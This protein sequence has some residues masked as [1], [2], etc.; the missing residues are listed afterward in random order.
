MKKITLLIFMITLAA[1]AQQPFDCN[2]GNFYQVISGVM[3]AYDPITGSYSEALHSYEAYNAGGY[4]VVD[5]YL[6]AIKN[7]DKH[8]LRVAK[9]VVIDLGKVAANGSTQF[10][11]GYAADVDDLGNLWVFQNTDKQ[12]FHKIT[13]LS[14]YDGTSAPVFEIV[15]TDQAAPSNCA[16]IAFIDGA[17]YGGSKGKLFT[18]DLSSGTPVFSSKA[19][20]NLPNS[21]FGA[22]YADATNRLYLSDNKGG[23]YLINDY[24]GATPTATLL[25][26]T[27]TTNSNDGFKCASGISPLDRDQD[28]ILDS[29]D[30]DCDGDG[31]N[32]IVESKGI[33]PY[34]DHDGDAMYNYLDND[35]SG[36][37]DNVVQD[38]FDRDGDGNPDFLDVDSDN[39]GIYDIV[40][41]GEG[42]KDSNNDGIYNTL[43][44]GYMDSDHDGIAD[45]FDI[46]Q[47]GSD[48]IPIDTDHDTIY[49]CYDIDSDNDGIVDIIEGQDSESYTGLSG[50]DEDADGMDDAFDPDFGNTTN[51]T[52]NTDN[53]NDGYD[54]LDTDSDNN[55][56]LDQTEAYDYDGDGV[57][58]T[59][60][61]GIDNDEDG[62]DDNYDLKKSSFDPENGNQNPSSFPVP[63]I[64]DRYNYLGDFSADGTPLYLDERDT[65]SQETLD[66]I[67]NALPE[68]YP[69]P[70]YNPHYISSGYDTD[71][72]L[73]EQADIWVT[74]VGEGA[75]YKNTLGFYTYDKDAPSA[76]APTPEDITI[77]F[78]NVSAAGSG[79]SLQVGDKVKIGTFPA[80]TGIGWVLLANAWSD[81]CVGTGHWQVHSNPDY[82]PESNASLR[83][84]NVLL[85]DPDNE[86][87]ILGFEDIRR[88]YASCDQDFNDALFYITANPYDAMV[89]TNY[90]HIETATPVTSGN[91][92]GLES[93]GDLANLIAKR[94]FI[95][96]KTNAVYDTKK[97]QK[98]F[99]PGIKSYRSS[100]NEDLSIHFPKTGLLGTETTYVSSPEDLLGITNAQSVFSVDYYNGEERVAAAL[101]TSTKG[102]IYDHSKTI[103]DR[104]NGSTL[105]DVR[106]VNIK[107]HTLVSTR[108]QRATGEIEYTLTFSVR[109]EDS[110]NE[111]YSLWNI[112][113]YPAG[114][115]VNF[116][117]WG[118]SV[119]Q[120]SKIAHHI[121]DSFLADKPMRSHKVAQSIPTVFAQKGTYANGKLTLHIIN[122]EGATFMNF[123][124]NIRKTEQSQEENIY[125]TIALS[126][127]Y[128]EKITIPTG[129]LFDIGFSILGEDA[130]KSDALYLAD[131]PWGID[132][133]PQGAIVDTFEV[134]AHSQEQEID[135]ESYTIERN[136]TV[137]GEVK[138]TLNLFRNILAGDLTMDASAYNAVK[139]KMNTTTKVE[140]ILVTEGLTDWNN[141]LRY[142]IPAT[143]EATKQATVFTIPFADFKNNANESEAITNVRGIVFSIQGDYQHFVPFT[144]GVSDLVLTNTTKNT[145]APETEEEIAENEV[146]EISEE[147][148]VQVVEED[149]KPVRLMNY[150]NPFTTMTTLQIPNTQSGV[151]NITVFDMLGRTVRQEQMTSKTTTYIFRTNDLTPGIYQYIITGT[152]GQTY[153]GNFLIQ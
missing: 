91:N 135:E 32:N 57:A 48:F 146:A 80:N 128:S 29:M 102:S 26:L 142:I 5:N 148:T 113:D 107:N 1:T 127:A 64:C 118:G 94:N 58:E 46:D 92:G 120:V 95:R 132:Y 85:S 109:K 100:A 55:G 10:G 150:P 62:L 3:K 97:R 18:W 9:D 151:T 30:S 83:Y 126:G 141:R 42:S 17:F 36:N 61:S 153:I 76:T 112:G 101:A 27:E 53:Q 99:Q 117:V 152:E 90:V 15:A 81:G 138:E 140:I 136:A 4:N 16:D 12:H 145:I 137:Q 51:G 74:F 60:A 111:I 19:V 71:V 121:L 131:G 114:D 49:D 93:N 133:L 82:N 66:M 134:S 45:S 13:N 147:E 47:T 104:L 84:H 129:H 103:C 11:G 56:V 23:L 119:S 8:L 39:D 69:V 52:I 59:T 96:T 50:I 73:E 115:Y 63:E 143:K 139:F 105:L 21:T 87:I 98:S 75:G 35:F 67:N 144:I 70:E 116:Q 33:D 124:G 25:N 89:T 7:S 40:E 86:R 28:G 54:H 72:I 77:V 125:K 44:S 79:G 24:T 31:I 20:A 6:Y 78:P 41:A 68:G 65:I 106:T 123:D 14:T 43:D 37:G 149:T 110:E 22:A 108:I 2:E 88:D 38:A 34:G 122:K 130:T